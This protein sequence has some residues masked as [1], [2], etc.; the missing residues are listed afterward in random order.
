MAAPNAQRTPREE[1]H[2]APNSP[3]TVA[4]K[5]NQGRRIAGMNGERMLFT[6]C[7]DRV[8]FTSLEVAAQIEASGV[9][10]REPFTITQVW[11][12]TKTS[13]RTW[14][15]TRIAGPGQLAVPKLPDS[16][17]P[18]SREVATPKP[19]AT[20]TA[21]SPNGARSRGAEIL[22][23]ESIEL[24]DAYAAVL[25]HALTAHNGRVKPDEV[26]SIFLTCV[27][28]LAGGKSRAA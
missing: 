21:A 14:E 11:D 19:P 8:F 25:N 24:V 1:I 28:N 18:G 20:A 16:P 7:D 9:N 6:T 17:I 2:F 5:Y 26:K 4:L 3:V 27:I 12:G 13:P 23:A 22:I 15:V 10:V